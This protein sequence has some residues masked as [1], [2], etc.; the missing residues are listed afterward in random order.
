MTRKKKVN[1]VTL[2]KKSGLSNAEIASFFDV[3]E[4]TARR[5]HTCRGP[6]PKA[7]IMCL[8]SLISGDPIKL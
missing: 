2:Q 4:T 7:V 6:A 3:D 1:Y 5:W 8:E